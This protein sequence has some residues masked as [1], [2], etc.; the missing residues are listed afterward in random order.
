[1][2]FVFALRKCNICTKMSLMP[3][4]SKRCYDCYICGYTKRNNPYKKK[5]VA[6]DG[7]G[8]G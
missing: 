7:G 2:S 5:L 8:R 4:R 1:M 3:P 6:K